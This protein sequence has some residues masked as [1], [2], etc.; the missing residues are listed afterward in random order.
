MFKRIMQQVTT[1]IFYD[2]VFFFVTWTNCYSIPQFYV[3]KYI[4]SIFRSFVCCE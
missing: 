4:K 1:Y 3:R 2:C